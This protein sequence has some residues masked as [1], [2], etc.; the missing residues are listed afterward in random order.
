[1]NAAFEKAGA[2]RPT[3]LNFG[4]IRGEIAAREIHVVTA[5]FTLPGA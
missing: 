1:V 4:K 3:R 5:G 2:N